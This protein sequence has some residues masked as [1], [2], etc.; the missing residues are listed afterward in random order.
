MSKNRGLRI[1][2]NKSEEFYL[3]Q[4]YVSNC[5]RNTENQ[6]CVSFSTLPYPLAPLFQNLQSFGQLLTLY[7]MRISQFLS[8]TYG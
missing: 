7:G 1:A 6:A 5:G 3:S 8:Y 2:E 4:N